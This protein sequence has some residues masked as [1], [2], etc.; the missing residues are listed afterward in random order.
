MD[1]AEVVETRSMLLDVLHDRRRPFLGPTD[2][3][4][5]EHGHSGRN[6]R[7]EDIDRTQSIVSQMRCVHSRMAK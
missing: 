1:I 2:D 6:V 4:L 3:I 5:T 7:A